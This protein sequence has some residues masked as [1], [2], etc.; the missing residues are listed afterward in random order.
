MTHQHPALPKATQESRGVVHAFEG[1]GVEDGDAVGEPVPVVVPACARRELGARVTSE[2]VIVPDLGPPF[3]RGLGDELGDLVIVEFL[4]V[5]LGRADHVEPELEGVGAVPWEMWRD[6]DGEDFAVGK[7]DEFC[8]DGRERHAELDG[9]DVVELH[10]VREAVAV[11]EVGAMC[12]EEGVWGLGEVAREGD[13]VV[14][15]RGEVRRVLGAVRQGDEAQT[16]TGL[17]GQA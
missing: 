4:D 16:E 8:S 3:P 11:L 5:L 15:V 2:G 1:D 14:H 10:G 7:V 13:G 17:R 9:V 6:P 12:G